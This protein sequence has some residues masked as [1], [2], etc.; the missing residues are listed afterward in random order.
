M[1]IIL[2]QMNVGSVVCMNIGKV[3]HAMGT[4]KVFGVFDT[5]ALGLLDIG[6]KSLQ[7]NLVRSSNTIVLN[8][9]AT[10]YSLP[11]RRKLTSLLFSSMLVRNVRTLFPQPIR[12]RAPSSFYFTR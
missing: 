4:I 12:A 2:G 8:R 5:I 10:N 3:D 6:K 11:G 1:F 9:W 7:I